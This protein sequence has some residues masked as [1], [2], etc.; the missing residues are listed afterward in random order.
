MVTRWLG[1]C[2]WMQCISLTPGG[3]LYSWGSGDEG[4]IG[5]GSKKRHCIPCVVQILIGN[6]VVHIT[7]TKTSPLFGRNCNRPL[8]AKKI[9][10]VVLCCWKVGIGG[11][12]VHSNLTFKKALIFSQPWKGSYISW[13][14]YLGP[15]FLL[16]VTLRGRGAS[17]F[18]IQFVF[19]K[20]C[21]NLLIILYCH[22][23]I[24]YPH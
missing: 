18:L 9:G 20:T 7:A 22:P 13:K 24:Y 16:S 17:Y 5:H 10:K 11:V 4:R 14:I 6:K 12:R 8:L 21:L 15:S 23:F 19:N 2:G 1:V 3:H